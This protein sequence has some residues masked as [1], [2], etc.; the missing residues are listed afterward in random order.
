VTEPL[1]VLA[2][3]FTN[4]LAGANERGERSE[5]KTRTKETWKYKALTETATRV[6]GR[7]VVPEHCIFR[8]RALNTCGLISKV[9]SSEGVSQRTQRQEANKENCC[10]GDDDGSAKAQ[11]RGLAGTNDGNTRRASE[12]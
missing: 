11:R 4:P 2:D 7:S 8:W 1:D 6:K 10:E 3:I 5:A 9:Q 12:G